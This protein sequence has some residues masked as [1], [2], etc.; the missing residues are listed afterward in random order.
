MTI[1]KPLYVPLLD[2][3]NGDVKANFM[4][5]H[6]AAFSGR[7]V[8]MSRASDSHAGRGMNKVA[9][10]FLL[11]GCDVWINID[12]DIHFS[13]SDIDK[14]IGHGLPLV[15]GVYPKKEE[16]TP[17]CIATLT[18]E[19][20]VP[21]KNG[22]VEVRRCGRGFMLIHR[23]LLENMKEE[24][25]GHAKRY[26]N[27]GRPEWEF[28]ESGVVVGEMSA[29]PDG[30]PEWISEDWYFCERARAM[31]VKVFADSRIVLGHEGAKVYQFNGNQIAESDA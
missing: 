27:H 22:L 10:D 4:L 21:D 13:A 30:A 20:P 5:C 16:A 19:T 15:Y 31:G 6:S 24:C 2:N 17:A 18:D 9:A 1:G 26:E 3:G 28:F 23:E 12:A 8:H 14:L 7:V 11:S 29:A 25:G